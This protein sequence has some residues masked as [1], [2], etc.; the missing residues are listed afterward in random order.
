M[1]LIL[2]VQVS[3][4][5]QLVDFPIPCTRAEAASYERAARQAGMT[6]SEWVSDVLNREAKAVFQA[7]T[8]G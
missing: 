7:D 1:N 4:T 6:L 3:D 5:P 8:K 2:S